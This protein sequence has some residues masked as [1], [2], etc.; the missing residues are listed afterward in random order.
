MNQKITIHYDF[1]D[2]SELSYQE[3]VASKADFTTNCLNFFCADNVNAKVIRA[4]GKSISVKDLLSGKGDHTDKK[5]RVAHNLCKML[6]AGK[7]KW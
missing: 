3:A 6:I 1:T 5:I 4:D 7:F 2:G